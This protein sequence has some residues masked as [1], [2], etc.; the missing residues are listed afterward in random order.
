[1][2]AAIGLDVGGTKI[3]AGIV[4]RGEAKVLEKRLLATRAERPGEEICRDA[5][6]TASELLSRA[7]TLGLQPAGSGIA[8]PELVDPGGNIR[9][10]AV[11]KWK[12]LPVRDRFARLAPTC[13][14][15]AD[16]R[17]AALGEARYGAGRPFRDFFYVGVG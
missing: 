16:A 4:L 17:A 15:E 6:E 9:T 7:K 10:G 11:L 12:D 13:V 5:Y 2:E 14:V 3:A 1:M 8:V